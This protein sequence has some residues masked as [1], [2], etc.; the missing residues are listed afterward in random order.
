MKQSRLPRSFAVCVTIFFASDEFSIFDKNSWLPKTPITESQCYYFFQS[1]VTNT[2]SCLPSKIGNAVLL[3]SHD[4]ETKFRSNNDRYPLNVASTTNLYRTNRAVCR[5]SSRC[6]QWFF[7]RLA[8]TPMAGSRCHYF[9]QPTANKYVFVPSSH[10]RKCD[11]TSPHHFETKSQSD[12]AT[13]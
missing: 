13:N 4:F 2:P 5:A 12:N 3:S 1:P 6:A 10:N 7:R 11:F 8:K 9:F